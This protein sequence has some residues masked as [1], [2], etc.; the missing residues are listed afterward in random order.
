MIYVIKVVNE[1]GEE[2]G[3]FGATTSRTILTKMIR[4]YMRAVKIDF[5]NGY[6]WHNIPIMSIQEIN[7][8]MQG[9]NTI[10]KDCCDDYTLYI[11]EWENGYCDDR[12]M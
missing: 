2:K 3:V 9:A 12:Y 7:D 4:K 11:E 6:S 10:G 8:S 5:C 1:Y